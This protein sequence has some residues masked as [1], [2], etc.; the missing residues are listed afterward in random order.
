MKI[1]GP[2]LVKINLESNKHLPKM[3]ST[4]YSTKVTTQKTGK[5]LKI[6]ER[7]NMSPV[8]WS[9]DTDNWFT[10]NQFTDFFR[11]IFCGYS[12]NRSIKDFC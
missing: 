6:Q 9:S 2:N 10:D 11:V 12:F 3:K 4:G 8:A 1:V 5:Y 7:K